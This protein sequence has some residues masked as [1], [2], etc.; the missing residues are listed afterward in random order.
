ML[1]ESMPFWMWGLMSWIFIT[2]TSAFKP[3][4]KQQFWLVTFVV[5]A[6]FS[7]AYILLFGCVVSHIPARV[8]GGVVSFVD[9]NLATVGL[10][11]AT[12]AFLV[13]V[14]YAFRK[15]YGLRGFLIV[16]IL[17]FVL[18]VSSLCCAF[19][20]SPVFLVA[21]GGGVLLELFFWWR[22][23]RAASVLLNFE[24]RS[25]LMPGTITLLTVFTTIYLKVAMGAW[26]TGTYLEGVDLLNLMVLTF[27]SI[28]LTILVFRVLRACLFSKKDMSS[29][30]ESDLFVE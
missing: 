4:V 7:I 22:L 24:S 6:V 15:T 23:R 28:N 26:M 12:L 2:S 27:V 11:V 19:G 13:L 29:R 16:P 1:F 8:G 20:F 5:Q 25:F 21:L 9:I 10:L 17:L 14:S 3:G 18:S 30:A